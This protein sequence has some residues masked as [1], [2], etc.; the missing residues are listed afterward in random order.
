MESSTQASLLVRRKERLE[1]LFS[2][3]NQ[4]GSATH[5]GSEYSIRMLAFTFLFYF[6][7]SIYDENKV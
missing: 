1:Q 5:G 4:K 2:G 7:A 3:A 6:L